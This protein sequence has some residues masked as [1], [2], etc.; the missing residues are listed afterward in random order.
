MFFD[1]KKRQNVYLKSEIYLFVLK[2]LVL[3]CREALSLEPVNICMFSKSKPH[4][5]LVYF[6]LASDNQRQLISRNSGTHF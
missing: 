5:F 6:N 2:C 1:Y 3:I 4:I